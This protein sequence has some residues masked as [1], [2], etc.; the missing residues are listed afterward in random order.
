MVREHSSWALAERHVI[1]GEERVQ[2]LRQLVAEM[3][4]RGEREA[5]VSTRKTLALC[6]QTLTLMREHLTYL[7]RHNR[8]ADTELHFS[9]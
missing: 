3:E 1:A 4:R 7:Q 5:A 6:E 9:A 2:R 8:L